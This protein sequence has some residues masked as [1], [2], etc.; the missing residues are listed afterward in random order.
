MYGTPGGH[1]EF[2]EEFEEC[3]SREL[4]EELNLDVPKEEIKYLTTLNVYNS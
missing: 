1:L 2:G 3:A 4:K